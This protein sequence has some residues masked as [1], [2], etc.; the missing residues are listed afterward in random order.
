[1]STIT[2]PINF[3]N[4]PITIR[5]I[6]HS[7]QTIPIFCTSSRG[8]ELLF[9]LL[10]SSLAMSSTV[11]VYPLLSAMCTS[12]TLSFRSCG[13]CLEYFLFQ[14]S[15]VFTSSGM[16]VYQPNSRKFSISCFLDSPGAWDLPFSLSSVTMDM[17]E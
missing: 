9:I 4:L 11:S 5:R 14:C 7:M 16:D 13:F 12:N 17:E 6:P 8:I 15:T 3:L 1:M 2:R 10:V